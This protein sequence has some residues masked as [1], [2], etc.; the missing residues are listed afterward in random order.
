MSKPAVPSRLGPEAK[1]LWRDVVNEYELRPDELRVLEDACR[2]VDLIEAL[3][4]ELGVGTGSLLVKGSTGQPVASPL[5][6]E[7]RQHRTALAR[8][9]ASLRLAADEPD[10]G[11]PEDDEDDQ[12]KADRAMSARAA[13]A[14]R[15]VGRG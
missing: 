2:E 12:A 9:L 14:A 10:E 4:K 3:R 7:I 8:L 11:E 15:W 5:L 13:A 1:A 6:R